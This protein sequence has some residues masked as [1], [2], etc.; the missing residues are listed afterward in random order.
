MASGADERHGWG[1]AGGCRLAAFM[2]ALIFGLALAVLAPL[3][4][5][6]AGAAGTDPSE[7]AAAQAEAD[8]GAGAGED[9][10]LFEALKAAP[11]EATARAI[12]N[13]I[14]RVWMQAPD[15]RTGE[16]VREAMARREVY[17]LAGAK[18]LLDEA[19]DRAPAYARSTTSAASCGFSRTISTGRSRTSTGRSSW[20]PGTSRQWRGGR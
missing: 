7:G 11:D 5:G 17:D 14:W 13:R 6:E 2:I 1:P 19:A 16:L 9:D 20:N 4:P 18:S 8:A 15:A 10:R 3:S 12:E